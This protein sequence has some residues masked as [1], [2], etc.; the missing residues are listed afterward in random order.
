MNF[1]KRF[2]HVFALIA[3]LMQ[4]SAHMTP[5]LAEVTGAMQITIC[6]GYGSKVITID[7][8]GEKVPEAPES[9]KKNCAVCAL[10]HIAAI[11]PTIVEIEPV[12]HTIARIDI[13]SSTPVFK[14]T[15]P[16]AHQTRGP[17]AL[18]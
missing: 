5:V 6:S 12:K 14:T 11:K 8:N 10:T 9:L 18:S 16:R 17:P 2:F 4:V 1:A 15:P 3:A 7:K 13:D